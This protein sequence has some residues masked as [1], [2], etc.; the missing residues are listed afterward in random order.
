[1]T[2]TGR[3]DQH[4]SAS[5]LVRTRMIF[6]ADRTFTQSFGTNGSSALQ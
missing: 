2:G 3:T 5:F 6:A 1:M 4:P